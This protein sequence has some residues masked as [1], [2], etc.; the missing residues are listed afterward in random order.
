MS[1]P[2]ENPSPAADAYGALA[3]LTIMLNQALLRGQEFECSLSLEEFR[4]SFKPLPDGKP[5]YEPTGVV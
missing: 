3:S 4:V 1:Q 5:A 2:V